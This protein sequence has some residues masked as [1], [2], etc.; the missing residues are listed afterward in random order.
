MKFEFKFVFVFWKVSLSPRLR[1]DCRVGHG[2]VFY[3]SEFR[4]CV[5]LV[6]SGRVET[7][8]HY[9]ILYYDL[10]DVLQSTNHE[11]SS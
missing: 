5:I 3:Q 4:V 6:D 11:T 10:Y 7:G 2:M 8:G 1:A 9:E